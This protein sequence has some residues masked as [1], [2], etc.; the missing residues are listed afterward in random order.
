MFVMYILHQPIV[1]LQQPTSSNLSGA[2]IYSSISF[3]LS[4][5]MFVLGQ[6]YVK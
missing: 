1:I 3:C 4:V 6:K 5:F 2:V